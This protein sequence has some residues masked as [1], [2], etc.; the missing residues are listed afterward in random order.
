[1][2]TIDTGLGWSCD[3]SFYVD[4]TTTA[5]GVNRLNETYRKVNAGAAICAKVK[6]VPYANII[7]TVSTV[8]DNVVMTPSYN[9]T[10][11][12]VIDGVTWYMGVPEYGSADS[13]DYSD[14]PW[15]NENNP[16]A[17]VEDKNVILRAILTAANVNVSATADKI[18]TTDYVKTFVEGIEAETATRVNGLSSMITPVFDTQTIYAVGD[19]CIYDNGLYKCTTA[20][21]GAWS[22]NDFAS[23]NVMSEIQNASAGDITRRTLY[24][25][26]E[27]TYTVTFPTSPYALTGEKAGR[28]FMA[29]IRIVTSVMGTGYNPVCAGYMYSYQDSDDSMYTTGGSVTGTINNI[30]FT[31]DDYNKARCQIGRGGTFEKGFIYIT[32]NKRTFTLEAVKESSSAPSFADYPVIVDFYAIFA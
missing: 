14:F 30:N 22:A 21:S 19:Y 9:G 8:A 3:S 10:Y 12:S 7:Y 17:D 13:T 16:F 5:L 24:I 32:R 20:H 29:E 25:N 6:R 28:Q 4:D 15:A 2:N 18:P 23:V 31:V 27:G 26:N 1:M 11:I